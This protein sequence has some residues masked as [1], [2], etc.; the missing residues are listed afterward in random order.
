MLKVVCT[1]KMG[2]RRVSACVCVCVCMFDGK[3]AGGE[4]SCEGKSLQ[5][6]KGQKRKRVGK[7][8]KGGK[9]RAEGFIVPS[10][11]C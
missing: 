10:R 9:K 1:P 5:T 8:R 2:V 7:E 11:P 3:L 6:N 4:G